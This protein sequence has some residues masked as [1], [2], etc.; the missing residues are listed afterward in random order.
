MNPTSASE[1]DS[2]LPSTT[3]DSKNPYYQASYKTAS[4]KDEKRNA[5]Q[6]SNRNTSSNSQEK[7]PT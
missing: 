5:T 7:K 4:E 2:E 3:N 6:A 1:K